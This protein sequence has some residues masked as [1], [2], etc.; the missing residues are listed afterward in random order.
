MTGVRL[1]LLPAQGGASSVLAC[2]HGPPAQVHLPPRRAVMPK[3]MR[4]NL[5]LIS[6]SSGIICLL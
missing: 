6:E 2:E 3:V 1:A 4:Q 5:V